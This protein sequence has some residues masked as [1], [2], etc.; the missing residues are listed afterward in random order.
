MMWSYC[1]IE[2]R[3]C[4]RMSWLWCWAMPRWPPCRPGWD[5]RCWAL[6]PTG[7]RTCRTSWRWRPA[8]R[9]DSAVIPAIWENLRKFE[10]IWKA[11]H[12]Q[13]TYIE[14]WNFGQVLKHFPFASDVV[15]GADD[16]HMLQ[17]VV[18]EVGGPQR[19]DQ[20]AQSDQRRV[21][22]GKEADDD[23]TVQHRHGRLIAILNKKFQR[24]RIQVWP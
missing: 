14:H 8:S 18:M 2:R 4:R 23:V 1:A 19:H 21:R 17:L 13:T 15:D 12:V 10:K 3:W 11:R 7:W 6:W 22:V 16:D 5:H 24:I 9:L 20:I